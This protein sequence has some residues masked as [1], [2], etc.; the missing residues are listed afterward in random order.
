MDIFDLLQSREQ[1]ESR[2]RR[3]N[4]V[5]VGIVTNNKD[6]LGRVRVKFQWHSQDYETDWVRI[7]TLMAGP[8]RGSFFIP[9]VGD[10]VLLAFENGD[11]NS[12]YVVGC[13]WSIED[14]PP[15]GNA[16]G[17]NNIRMFQ[18]RSGHEITFDDTNKKGHLQIQTK[19]GHS[20][21]LDDTGE[22]IVIED[23]RGN[24][25]KI[26]SSQN[27]I[28]ISSNLDLKVNATTIEIEAKGELKLSAGGTI[29]INGTL[30]TI[31]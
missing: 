25:I 19:S 14:N 9:E 5:V 30:V 4:G 15:S 13:L 27:S 17:E 24:S 21:L 26:D 6:E 23:N 11:F 3:I 12:P 7:A 28:S 16:D 18:S 29:S 31:N 22:K 2:A 8:Q 1:E 20:I 10:E